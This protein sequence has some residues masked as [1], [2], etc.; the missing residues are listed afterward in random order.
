MSV[1]DINK[2]IRDSHK[3]QSLTLLQEKAAYVRDKLSI[4]Y[5]ATPFIISYEELLQAA[6]SEDG[7]EVVNVLLGGW[8]GSFSKSRRGTS[9]TRTWATKEIFGPLGRENL[10]SGGLSKG[11]PNN[12]RIVIGRTCQESLE[13]ID[14]QIVILMHSQCTLDP[15]SKQIWISA[16]FEFKKNTEQQIFKLLGRAPDIPQPK[17]ILKGAGV[18]IFVFIML[19]MAC[20]N[21]TL[22]LLRKEFQA[23]WDREV[24]LLNDC[25]F[26]RDMKP[27]EFEA[28]LIIRGFACTNSTCKE[29]GQCAEMCGMCKNNN[30]PLPSAVASQPP[31]KF[32]DDRTAA[33]NLF[34][35]AHPHIVD[36]KERYA[37]FLKAQPQWDWFKV[38]PPIKTDSSPQASSKET[39]CKWIFNNQEKIALPF[40]LA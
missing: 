21:Q 23:T 26:K 34:D 16:L 20:V 36:P 31:R 24:K 9:R 17:Y 6:D 22:S 8:S 12:T 15:T 25:H 3:P 37:A 2:S 27:Q 5:A 18:S 33:R 29:A 30:V 38:S 4:F 10:T 14:S 1:T 13:S 32:R 11:S 19:Q 28:M 40:T 7:L 35:A 39:A